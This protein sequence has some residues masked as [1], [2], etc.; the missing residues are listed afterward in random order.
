MLLDAPICVSASQH[1]EQDNN[2]FER[3][4]IVIHLAAVHVEPKQLNSMLGQ[5]VTVTGQLF[6]AFT[7]HHRTP[8]LLD[9]YGIR[10]Q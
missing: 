1:P 7:G 10:A 9:V 3:E 6:H 2:G 8:V 4:Q 5:R